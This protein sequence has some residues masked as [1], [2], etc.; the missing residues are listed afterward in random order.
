M[1]QLVVALG[2]A[3]VVARFS[4]LNVGDESNRFAMAEQCKDC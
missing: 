2:F 1:D 3:A 4:R